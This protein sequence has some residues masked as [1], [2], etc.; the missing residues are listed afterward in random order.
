MHHGCA[1]SVD[2]PGF[3][4]KFWFCNENAGR[5]RAHIRDARLLLSA[6]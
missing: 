6:A 3:L 2:Y 1:G 5:L 4:Q